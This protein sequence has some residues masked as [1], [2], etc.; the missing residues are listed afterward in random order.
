MSD[1][2]F[3]CPKCA[4]SYFGTTD[5]AD[6]DV[7]TWTRN[8]HDQFEINCDWH[9]KDADC[10]VSAAVAYDRIRGGIDAAVRV[11]QRKLREAR[12]KAVKP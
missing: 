4:G 3:S 1:K 6:P 9:G 10:M 11:H 8:C 2:V 7:S 12:L 5:Y